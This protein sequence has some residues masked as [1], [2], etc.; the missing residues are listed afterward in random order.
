MIY[1]LFRISPK[2]ERYSDPPQAPIMPLLHFGHR[3][4]RGKVHPSR[5]I[6]YQP[7]DGL[8]GSRRIFGL[9]AAL[10]VIHDIVPFR[11]SGPGTLIIMY[12]HPLADVDQSPRHL[13]NTV[14]L[15]VPESVGILQSTVITPSSL[16]ISSPANQTVSHLPRAKSASVY[17]RTTRQIHQAVQETS[18]RYLGADD[19]RS[20]L[21]VT[22]SPDSSFPLSN[23]FCTC[24]SV[25]P[26]VRDP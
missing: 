21:L 12:T 13:A 8:A 6:S 10:I 15:S 5:D 16:L 24:G 25:E 14:F 19:T 9:Q 4:R 18:T 11:S 7:E 20:I 17:R 2:A 23:R 22:P 26:I 1:R 3:G